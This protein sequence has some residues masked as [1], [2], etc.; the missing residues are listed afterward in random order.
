MVPPL[1]MAAFM[2][3]DMKTLTINS[4]YL[5]G[6][7]AN[8]YRELISIMPDKLV[9]LKLQN[10]IATADLAEVWTDNLSSVESIKDVGLQILDLQGIPLG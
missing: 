9:E 3:P 1:L 8:T 7:A 4:N 10:S 2:N 5:R 6:S